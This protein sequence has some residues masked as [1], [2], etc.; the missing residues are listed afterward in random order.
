MNKSMT[1]KMK[2][3]KKK[4]EEVEEGGTVG[5]VKREKK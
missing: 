4:V 1:M 5:S 3:T 2:K